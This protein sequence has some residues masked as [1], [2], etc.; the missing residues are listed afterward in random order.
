MRLYSVVK[1]ERATKLHLNILVAEDNPSDRLLLQMALT[2]NGVEVNLHLVE[3]GSEAIQYLEGHGPFANRHKHPIPDL[4]LLDLKMQRLSGFDV[5]LW[6]RDRPHCA[7]IPTVVLSGSGLEQDIEQA[8]A[9][10][11]K[12]YFEKP[13]SFADFGSL[14]QLL[15]EY[16]ARSKRPARPGNC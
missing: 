4:I 13:T 8:Y 7:A 14:L 15:I 5:L 16:W 11:A 2:R 1:A 3:D 9:L 12:T 10:G 6:L